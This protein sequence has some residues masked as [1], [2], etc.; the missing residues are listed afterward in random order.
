MTSGGS[1][2][3]TISSLSTATPKIDSIHGS[4][5][6]SAAQVLDL[7]SP[8]DAGKYELLTLRRREI[9]RSLEIEGRVGEGR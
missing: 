3:I 8:K 4:G 5:R 2:A 6:K 9:E 1:V 7:V